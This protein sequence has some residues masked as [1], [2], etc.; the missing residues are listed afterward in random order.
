MKP[1]AANIAI[2]ELCGKRW[3]KPTES[4]KATGSYYQYEPNYWHSRD[5]CAEFEAGMSIHESIRYVEA[6]EPIVMRDWNVAHPTERLRGTDIKWF[7]ATATAP[8]GCEAFLRMHG[9]WV[10]EPKEAK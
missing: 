4:E 10:E 2:A 1:E 7:L 3:H 9:K 6:L 8:Q 5:A